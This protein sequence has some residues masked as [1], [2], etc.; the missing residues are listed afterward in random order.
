MVLHGPLGQHSGEYV[1]SVCW[2]SELSKFV[3]IGYSGTYRAMT[4]SDGITWSGHNAIANN[5]YSVCWSPELSKFVAVAYNGTSS[6]VM[7]SSDGSTWS[8]HIVPDSNVWN[9]VC[10]SSELSIFVAVSSDG[11]YRVMT[12]PDGT[13]W[14]SRTAAEDTYWRDVCWSPELSL[15]VAVASGG[16]NRVM[17]SPDGITWTSRTSTSACF[18]VCWSPELSIFVASGT[19]GTI[20]YSPDGINWTAK[21][22]SGSNSWY[23]VCWSPEL[24][25]FVAVANS[26]TNRVITS[27]I[28][29]PNSKSVVKALPTQMSVLPNGNVGIG[30]TS[31]DDKLHIKGGNLRI[32]NSGS[33]SLDSKIIFE[34]TGY[35]DRFFIA[36]DLQNVSAGDQHL[37]FGYTNGGDSGITNSNVLFDIA[38]N[39]K[40][41]IGTT[42]PDTLLHIEKGHTG[43]TPNGDAM[44]ILERND[45]NNN[46]INF[47]TKDGEEAGLLFASSISNAQGGITYRNTDGMTFRTGV[48]NTRMVIDETG[49][50][51]IGTNNPGGILDVFRSSSSYGLIAQFGTTNGPRVRIGNTNDNGIILEMSIVQVT[52]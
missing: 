25:I 11:T 5:W 23:S 14:T 35:N 10:W 47:V 3:A 38:G 1:Y 19:S 27:N 17:T 43:Y 28:G 44:L 2:S 12:S 16:T 6:R 49:N 51:G 42:S 8:G 40:V 29:M 32:E 15:F 34:E 52:H 24:S 46:W 18:S 50:V 30:T 33:N 7:T 21:S 39:G 4:S 37:R 31:P 13:T 22:I 45:S 20:S 48:N 41:G 36:T 9:A 26:G